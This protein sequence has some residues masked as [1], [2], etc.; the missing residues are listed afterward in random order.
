VQCS[1][2]HHFVLLPGEH[3][4]RVDVSSDGECCGRASGGVA[5]ATI[6]SLVA[7]DGFIVRLLQGTQG[8]MRCLQL[9]VLYSRLAAETAVDAPPSGS[10]AFSALRMP[11]PRAKHAEHFM[12]TPFKRFSPTMRA[13]VANCVYDRVTSV[14]VLSASEFACYEATSEE[15]LRMALTRALDGRRVPLRQRRR[16]R[17]D[18]VLYDPTHVALVWAHAARTGSAASMVPDRNPPRSVRVWLPRRRGG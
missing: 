3:V 16:S 15:P 4:T 8:G 1:G 2:L 11:G 13:V 12:D 17:R 5:A 14:H 6:T 7:P 18:S 9:G 10:V